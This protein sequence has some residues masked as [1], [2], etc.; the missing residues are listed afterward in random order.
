[1]RSM[2]RGILFLTLVALSAPLAAPASASE[3]NADSGKKSGG[4]FGVNAGIATGDDGIGLGW[5]VGANYTLAHRFGPVRLRADATF[6]DHG[7]DLSIFGLAAN[8]V[9]PIRRIYGVAGLG[10]YDEDSNGSD[11]AITLGA[12]IRRARGMYFEARWVDIGGFTTF[13]IVVGL[14]F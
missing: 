4:A 10:W 2:T 1:M 11:I 9:I 12:G 5:L 14:T 8:A 3:P 7:S 6:Q 13:P